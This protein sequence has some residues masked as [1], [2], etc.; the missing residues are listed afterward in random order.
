[1][2][3]TRLPRP[4]Q[5]D[6]VLDEGFYEVV[7]PVDGFLQQ[8]PIEGA[9]ATE[10]TEAWVFFDDENLYIS[11]RIWDSAPESRWVANEMLRDSFQLVQNE[12]FGI[13][14]DTFYDRRNGLNFM[15]NPLG[16]FGDY[17][18]T[19]ES[20]PNID[21][22]PIWDSATGRFDGGWTL[23][24]QIPFKSLRFR[25][26]QDAQVW[27]M[28]LTRNIRWKNEVAHMTPVPISGGPGDFR[29]SAAGTLTGVEVPRGNRTF[30][31]KPYAIGGSPPTS[32]PCPRS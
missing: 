3:A 7:P 5:L 12:Y 14:L 31:I 21:W 10:R 9:P 28:Q 29:L 11:A 1:M 23:E 26:G 8:M 2:R 25:P 15:I 20:N 19:D 32:T 24:T 18:I 6:G 16:G 27:G 4:L 13:A 30:E 22:N 17:Q